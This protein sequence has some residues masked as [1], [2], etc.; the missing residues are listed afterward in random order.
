MASVDAYEAKTHLSRLLDRAAR[1]EQITITQHGIPVAMLVPV[2]SIEKLDPR[3]VIEKLR[4][5]RCGRTLVT[6][7]VGLAIVLKGPLMKRSPLLTKSPESSI[8]G[9]RSIMEVTERW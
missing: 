3:T 8:I 9:G 4:A 7:I 2:S 1:G 5:F 6:S